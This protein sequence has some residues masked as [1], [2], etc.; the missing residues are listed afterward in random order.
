[1]PLTPDERF[2]RAFRRLPGCK[3]TG[4]DREDVE[5]RWRWAQQ[6]TE[7]GDVR[8]VDRVGAR[9]LHER[10]VF[11]GDVDGLRELGRMCEEGLGGPVDRDRARALYESAAE[12]G[13]DPFERRR[14]AEGGAWR[15]TPRSWRGSGLHRREVAVDGA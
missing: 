14:L 6:A 8:V 15:G 1:M 2:Q 11:G 13:A 4:P 10:A 3:D 5:G 7:A 12:V 9:A